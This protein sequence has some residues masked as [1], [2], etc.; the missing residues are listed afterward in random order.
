MFFTD[1]LDMRANHHMLPSGPR[2][3]VGLCHVKRISPLIHGSHVTACGTS[4]PI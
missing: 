4:R 3:Y 1:I 2:T